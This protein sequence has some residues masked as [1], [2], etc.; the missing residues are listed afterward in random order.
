MNELIQ[1]LAAFPTATLHEAMGKYG[2]LP[3]GI[4][5][6]SPAMKVCGTAVTVHT[7]PRDNMML[8]HAIAQATPGDVI[9][10]HCSDF[11]E[12]GYWGEIMAVGAQ[13]RGLAGLIIDGCVRDADPIIT[14]GFPVFARGLCIHGTTKFGSGTLNQPITIGP[15]TINPG[16]VVVGD[17]DGV[18][19]V[20][21]DHLV[22]TI[23]KA[24]AREAKEAQVMER[25]RNGETT[26]EIYGW[27]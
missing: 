5:P 16:D 2:A 9:I 21:A 27:Q 1:Q 8:H 6:L 19:I 26:L 15:I 22:N 10:A 18:V 24:T 3:S 20:P 11:W 23:N 7:M 17:R 25:L 14:L 4:K 13:A 12:A